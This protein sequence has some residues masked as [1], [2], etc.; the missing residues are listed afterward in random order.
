MGPDKGGTGHPQTALGAAGE[1]RWDAIVIGAGPSGSMAAFHLASRGHRVLL[2][3]RQA[4][5]REK[6]CGDALIPDAL[7]C[8]RRAGLWQEVRA[9]GFVPSSA[10]V[11]SPSRFRVVIPGEYLTLKREAL[12]DLLARAAVRAGAQFV[13]GS[14]KDVRPAGASGVEVAFGE[15][16][17]TFQARIVL[18]ATGADVSLPGK[19]GLLVEPSPSAFAMRCYVRSPLDLDQLVITYDRTTLPG[20]AWVFP[21]GGGEFNVG[22]GVAT[23]GGVPPVNLK[24]AFQRVAQEF[25]VARDLMAQATAS[26]PLKGARLRCG[27]SGTRPLGQGPVMA[28]GEAIGATFPYTGEGIGKA[29]E[30]GE[31]AAELIHE[32]LDAGDEASLGLYPVRLERS[33]R[34][35]YRAYELAERWFSRPWLNDWVVRRA[36]GSARIRTRLAEIFSE[37]A[38]PDSVF[39]TWGMVRLVVGV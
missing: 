26:T 17:R 16:P 39:S 13:L 4:F 10:V 24:A 27:L 28:A 21:M 1:R 36:S 29:M 23:S 5:P 14:A 32:A 38:D 12:D 9:A 30:T 35:R 3:D 22:C 37:R 25:P 34:P 15:D 31:M 19:A 33:L 20:Y 18:L 7:A 8:L 6:V 2:V 11:Y